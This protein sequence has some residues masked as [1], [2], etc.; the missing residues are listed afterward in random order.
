MYPANTKLSPLKSRL[1]IIVFG[2][3]LTL[4]FTSC[5]APFG[6][7]Q[8]SSTPS[9]Q[10]GTLTDQQ[11]LEKYG[12]QIPPYTWDGDTS[13]GAPWDTSKVP[14]NIPTKNP[15]LNTYDP[16]A[17]FSWI[18][19]DLKN[20]TGSSPAHL[21]FFSHGEFI[22]VAEQK[23]FGKFVPHRLSP[24]SVEVRYVY[25]KADECNACATGRAISVYTFDPQTRQVSRTGEL[26][27]VN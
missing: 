23:P 7:E 14:E 3:L 5:G 27:P 25:P 19:M 1:R 10:C 15:E 13:E 2:A 8:S 26:P 24:T 22:G 20:G 9:Q 6:A 18:T 4:L 21:L 12:Q 11:A 17:E 16:C